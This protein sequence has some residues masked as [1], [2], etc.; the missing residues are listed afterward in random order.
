[1]IRILYLI[2]LAIGLRA[3]SLKAAVSSAAEALIAPAQVRLGMSLADL[4]AVRPKAFDGPSASK[5]NDPQKR[6]WPTM[7]EVIDLG[8][9]SQVSYWYLFSSDKLVGLLRIRNLVLVQPEAR[10]A[11]ASSGYNAIT[12][13]LGASRQESFLRKGDTSFV[14][15]SADVWT[16]DVTRRS[17]YYIATTKEITTVVLDQSD[18]PIEQVMIRPDPNRFEIE[19]KGTQTVTDLPRRQTT[20]KDG[21]PKIKE[22]SSRTVPSEPQPKMEM[23]PAYVTSPKLSESKINQWRVSLWLLF[24]AI[25]LVVLFMVKRTKKRAAQAHFLSKN[26]DNEPHSKPLAFDF[27]HCCRAWLHLADVETRTG[28]FE[29]KFAN[30]ACGSNPTGRANHTSKHC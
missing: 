18:F 14:T 26:N 5:T 10:N 1:M 30:S 9:P 17:F 7:M 19:D 16:D 27:A 13:L 4:K 6:K 20:G 24:I 29:C 3:T 8:Q 11:E 21:A 22:E 15:V 25:A 12:G 28:H 2:L 23:S